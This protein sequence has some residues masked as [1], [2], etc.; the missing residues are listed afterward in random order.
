MYFLLISTFLHAL[1]E[2]FFIS[3]NLSSPWNDC[4]YK[5]PLHMIT[6]SIRHNKR[7]QMIFC[8][9]PIIFAKRNAEL[10]AESSVSSKHNL[11]LLHLTD[12]VPRSQTKT[13]P[14][15]EKR[16][17][18][19]GFSHWLL[20]SSSKQMFSTGLRMFMFPFYCGKT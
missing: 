20:L 11:L 1:M 8:D 5:V 7:M 2:S 18:S 10:C 16:T 19:N 12:V 15:G 9:Y 4:I 13:L 6:P 3:N 17:M 14:I